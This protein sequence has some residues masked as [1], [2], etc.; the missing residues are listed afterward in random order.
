MPTLEDWIA[1]TAEDIQK[2]I[3]S[4]PNKT[5]KL[6]PAPMWLVKD[7]RGL[8]SPFILLL[9]SKSLTAGCFPAVF[10]EALVQPLLKK[11]WA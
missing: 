6:D 4:A 5:C 1:V 2:L 11:S 3:S 8:L 10:K 7:M 9:F